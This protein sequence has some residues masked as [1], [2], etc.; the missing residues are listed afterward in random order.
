MAHVVPAPAL[1]WMT[2]C[3]PGTSA[4]VGLHCVYAPLSRM[5]W[6]C[7]GGVVG[8]VPSCPSSFSPQHQ[9]AP[10]VVS[11]HPPPTPAPI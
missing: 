4:G 5:N 1:N 2:S 8:I 3:S 11:A 7:V 10:A 9:S 6:Q